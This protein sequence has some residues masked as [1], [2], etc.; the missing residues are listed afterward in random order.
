MTDAE[1]SAFLGRELESSRFL[2][3]ADHIAE[4]EICRGKLVSRQDLAAAQSRL[5]AELS[6]FVEHIPEDDL[7]KY[8]SGQLALARIRE[9]D[10]HL[11]KCVQC[12][13][14]LRDLR[15]FIAEMPSAR[16]F[17]LPRRLLAFAAVAA[18][19]VVVA[20]LSVRQPREIVAVNDV[21]G[22]VSLDQGGALHGIGSLPA[23]QQQAVRQAL[24]QQRFSL[25]ASLRELRGEPGALMGAAER[26]PFKLEAPVATVERSNRPTLS[27]TSDP[28]SV[29]Y[30]VTLKDENTGQTTMTAL[31]QTTFW[32]VSSD[33]ERGHSYIWQVVSSRKD[34][35]EVLVPQP[36]VPPAKFIVLDS[37]TDSNLQQ[38]PPSHLVRSVVYVN[39]G[40]LDDAD[41]ELTELQKLNPHSTLVGHLL[42][43]LRQARA[44]G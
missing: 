14:E 20:F 21:S 13:D 9:I 38:L 42:D 32:S 44:S 23:D 6:P 18:V 27:W 8:V 25:P 1:V 33:L 7:Q 3:C 39:A 35:A 11:A 4:C 36:P 22:R 37:V 17:L 10:G 12:A 43:Q 5:D 30:R 24:A 31:L 28:Q 40:L 19:V 26:A 41:R 15:N 29:G 34:G 16:T 2:D